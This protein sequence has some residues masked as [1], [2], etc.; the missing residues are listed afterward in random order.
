MERKTNGNVCYRTFGMSSTIKLDAFA[1]VLNRPRSDIYIYIHIY[2]KN[3]KEKRKRERE[4]EENRVLAL[5]RDSGS[6]LNCVRAY[7]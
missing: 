3:K 5:D 1:L 6:I 4:K 7:V 2:D